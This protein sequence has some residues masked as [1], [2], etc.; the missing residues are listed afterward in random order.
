MNDADITLVN[1]NMLLIR[2]VDALERE[3][4][5]P[6]GPL[7]LVTALE[8]AGLRVDFRDYQ[9]SD[10]A[11]PM[12]PSAVADFCADPAPIIGLSCM[13]NLLPF[14]ILAAKEIKA[15]Y[16]D[17]TLVLGGV[18]PKAVEAELLKRFPWIDLIAHGEGERSAVELVRALRDRG[19]LSRVPGLFLRGPHGIVRTESPPRIEDLE[20]IGLPAF[21]RIDY[22]RYAGHNV[23]TSRG[24][25]YECT[26]C[27]VAP[28]WGRTPHFRRPE[29][30]VR[31][32]RLLHEEQGVELFLFQDEFFVSSKERVHAFCDELRR[33]GLPV[34]WK[35]FARINLTDRDVLRAMAAAGCVEIR[36]GIESGS[37]EI[38]Q[39]VRKGF[40]I[41]E[42]TRVIAEAVHH[43]PRVDTFFIWGFPFETMEHFHQTIFQMIA[44][45]LLGAR[46]LP[47]L[48]CLLPQTDIYR[49]YRERLKLEFYPG[50]LPEYMLTG[51][52]VCDDG[53]L[54]VGAQHGFI[55]D[56]IREHPDLF[57]GFFHANLD[58][59][60]LPKFEILREHGFYAAKAH[61][62]TEADSCGAHSPR[63]EGEGSLGAI[64]R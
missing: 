15:R 17:R 29:A 58:T 7:Y 40:T 36:F 54:Q 12:L 14:T 56:F 55:F 53:H 11:E 8:E 37:N 50:L 31:E 16:P 28:V 44:F 59:N 38:L 52:E 5:V 43:F 20:S 6:L 26:F 33:S 21:G 1:L 3:L 13:A 22:P 46:I 10:A 23:I 2:Y 49:E 25:P 24:C 18:G 61:E 39:R 35:A 47:S 30:I 45:R 60:V 41:E 27:S 48:L 64:T 32:M 42:A 19:D 4:H 9:L 62:V 34:R 63:L 57:P 51:H